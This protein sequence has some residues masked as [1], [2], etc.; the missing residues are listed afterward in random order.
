MA[1]ADGGIANDGNSVITVTMITEVQLRKLVLHAK[2][3][4][5]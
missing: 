1:E 3:F 4:G 5:R 2:N